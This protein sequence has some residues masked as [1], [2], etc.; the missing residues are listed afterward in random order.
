MVLSYIGS[1]IADIHPAVINAIN[2]FESF[3]AKY[4]LMFTIPLFAQFLVSVPDRRR[5][6]WIVGGIT[7][8]AF[9]GQHYTVS[10]PA[11]KRSSCWSYRDAPTAGS[12]RPCL[13]L[14]TR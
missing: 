13:S 9:L 2:Y 7:L 11:K 12:A 3:P 4:L 5:K 6:N 1:N 10:Q 14:S 8:L